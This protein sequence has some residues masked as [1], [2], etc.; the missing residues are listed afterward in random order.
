MRFGDT[1][2]LLLFLLPF[3]VYM[4]ISLHEYMKVWGQIFTALSSPMLFILILGTES[5]NPELT[6]TSRLSLPPECWDVR[7]AQSVLSQTLPIPPPLKSCG[8]VVCLFVCFLKQTISSKPSGKLPHFYL[9]T[10][11]FFEGNL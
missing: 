9:D 3:G 10:T 6:D 5:V 1:F 7:I 4:F 11:V 2:L 8:F